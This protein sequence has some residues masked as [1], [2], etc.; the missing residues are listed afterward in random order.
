M[1]KGIN[2]KRLT[3]NI[4]HLRKHTPTEHMIAWFTAISYADPQKLDNPSESIPASGNNPPTH[5]GPMSASNLPSKCPVPISSKSKD[6]R[7]VFISIAETMPQPTLTPPGPRT[8][9][10]SAES[11]GFGFAISPHFYIIL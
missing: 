5:Q 4:Y 10:H 6:I 8:C 9:F 2:R 7:P 3:K 11:Y 1:V